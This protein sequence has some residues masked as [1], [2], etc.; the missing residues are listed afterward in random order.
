[1]QALANAD[2]EAAARYQETVKLSRSRLEEVQR[3]GADERSSRAAW[4]SCMLI[5]TSDEALRAKEAL[6]LARG[7]HAQGQLLAAQLELQEQKR[8]CEQVASER[9]SMRRHLAE[10]NSK[11]KRSVVESRQQQRRDSSRLQALQAAAAP[12]PPRESPDLGPRHCR[13]A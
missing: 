7:Q 3:V 6:M 5:T 13:L 11:M 9:E 10:V 4:L 2:S 8:A 1:M 12:A